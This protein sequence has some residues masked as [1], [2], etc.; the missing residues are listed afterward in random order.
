MALPVFDFALPVQPWPLGP[1][2][3]VTHG[4]VLIAGYRGSRAG[5]I[6][7]WVGVGAVAYLLAVNAAMALED[8]A[9]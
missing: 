5:L 8:C 6:I 2:E 9:S 3:F 7:C 1:G 4:A